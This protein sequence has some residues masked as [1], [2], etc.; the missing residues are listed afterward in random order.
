MKIAVFERDNTL[1]T[2]LIASTSI[3]LLDALYL[4]IA[5]HLGAYSALKPQSGWPLYLITYAVLFGGLVAAVEG[6]FAV[7]ALIGFYV[8][9]VYNITTLATTGYDVVSAIADLVYGT[10][11]YA[12]VFE[13]ISYV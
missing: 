2:W 13:L 3:L 9:A 7:G 6:T 11:A 4:T 5:V 1:E 10:L 8:F 12:T